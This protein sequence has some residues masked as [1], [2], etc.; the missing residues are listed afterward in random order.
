MLVRGEIQVTITTIDQTI[1]NCQ[2][3]IDAN[4][5]EILA[6]LKAG[7]FSE[8]EVKVLKKA[9]RSRSRWA[10]GSIADAAILRLRYAKEMP[11]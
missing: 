4:P 6:Q 1:L 11:R 10:R 9:V 7:D 8:Y 5:Q 2:K 3:A